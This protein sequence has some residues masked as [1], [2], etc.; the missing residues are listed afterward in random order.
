[1]LTTFCHDGAGGFALV[2]GCSWEIAAIRRR[3]GK[4]TAHGLR[5]IAWIMV[6]MSFFI[7]GSQ[8]TKGS[9]FVPDGWILALEF[10]PLIAG[11]VLLLVTFRA[12]GYS[13]REQD[14]LAAQGR[15]ARR[16]DLSR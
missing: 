1:L 11:F 14:A 7:I 4:P 15:H 8:I 2:A 13:K 9:Q 3:V 10:V 16:N 12:A 5:V 6:A